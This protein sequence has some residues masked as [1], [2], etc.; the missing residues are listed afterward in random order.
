MGT[1]CRLSGES[2]FVRIIAPLP[3]D[4]S[5]ELPYM[6]VAITLAKMLLP[7]TILNG[8]A[9]SEDVGTEQEVDD[10]TA[11]SEPLQSAM[12]V[13]N[14]TPSDCLILTV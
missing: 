14:V 11:A 10:T 1:S 9:S 12:L 5:I 6:L 13:E 7:H 8:A 2:G 3:P 4:D